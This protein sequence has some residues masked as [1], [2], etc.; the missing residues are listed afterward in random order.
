MFFKLKPVY[1][2]MDLGLVGG[3]GTLSS[4]GYSLYD[5]LNEKEEESEDD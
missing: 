2:E 5:W 3:E 1:S 4:S